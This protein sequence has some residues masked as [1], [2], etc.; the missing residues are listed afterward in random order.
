MDTI[1]KPKGKEGGKGRLQDQDALILTKIFFFSANERLGVMLTDWE[2]C[3]PWNF[4]LRAEGDH[5][6]PD[7]GESLV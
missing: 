3:C 4:E 5:W 1:K 2:G 7:Q 6:W